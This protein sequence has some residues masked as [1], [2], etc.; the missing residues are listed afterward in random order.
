MKVEEQDPVIG[1]V[2]V[3]TTDVHQVSI[4]DEAI[5][6]Q[7]GHD[8]SEDKPLKIIKCTMC[9]TL[10]KIYKIDIFETP[11]CQKCGMLLIDRT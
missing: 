9:D 6:F 7:V 2:E 8:H 1:D 10:N 4:N 11:S 5:S 3:T